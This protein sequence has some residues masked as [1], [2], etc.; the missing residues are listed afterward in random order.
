MKF[1]QRYAQNQRIE[2]I[3][4]QHLVIGIDIA[5][6][7]HVAR[8]VNFRGIEIGRHISF[9]NS[10]DGFTKL[11]HWYQKLQ[12]SHGYTSV[13]IGLEPTGHYWFSLADWLTAR[14]IELVLVEP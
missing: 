6:E 12:E 9:S 7:A 5:K 10:D 4:T 13:L 8:A 11:L 14:H 2:R 3:T 1:K